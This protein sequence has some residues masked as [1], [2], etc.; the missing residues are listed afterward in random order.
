M[1]RPVT[2]DSPATAATLRQRLWA[3]DGERLDA[4]AAGL[5]ANSLY[6]ADLEREVEDVRVSYIGTAVVEIAM[7]R[8]DLSGRLEG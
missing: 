7:L 3:L 6:M 5:G 1:L 4:L 8:A 2:Q